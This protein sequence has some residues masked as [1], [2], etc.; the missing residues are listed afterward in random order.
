MSNNINTIHSLN[1]INSMA[2]IHAANKL[3]NKIFKGSLPPTSNLSKNNVI[4][5]DLNYNNDGNSGS[6]IL[7]Y[8]SNINSFTKNGKLTPNYNSNT[9][10]SKENYERNSNITQENT[11]KNKENNYYVDSIEN[12]KKILKDKDYGINLSG[13]GNLARNNNMSNKENLVSKDGTEIDYPPH[14]LYNQ[15]S[16]GSKSKALKFKSL[17]SNNSISGHISGS[18]STAGVNIPYA[19]DSKIANNSSNTI[20][21]VKNNNYH[22]SIPVPNSTKSITM[23]HHT[24]NSVSDIEQNEALVSEPSIKNTNLI[25]N[26]NAGK[27]F[28]N[29]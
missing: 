22:P 24:N 3:N 28:I 13:K 15:V 16:Q 7:H 1:N 18:G 11:Y 19:K 29:I 23:V 14:L 17:N 20:L 25:S 2:K 27:Y 4:K 21:H 26:S 6:S 8:N 12:K 10:H 5:P 9:S